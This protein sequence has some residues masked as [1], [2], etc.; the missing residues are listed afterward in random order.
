MRKEGQ[1]KTVLQADINREIENFDKTG[2]SKY[3]TQQT[4][5]I[6]NK[7]EQTDYPHMADTPQEIAKRTQAEAHALAFKNTAF[8]QGVADKDSYNPATMID[9]PD[10]RGR[11]VIVESDGLE[12]GT[13]VPSRLDTYRSGYAGGGGF[14]YD[15]KT[16]YGDAAAVKRLQLE[17]ENRFTESRDITEPSYTVD[18]PGMENIQMPQQVAD[19]Y[20]ERKRLDT[21]GQIRAATRRQ[22]QKNIN[23]LGLDT[24][25]LETDQ[26]YIRP[27]SL[28]KMG[29]EVT[30]IE[31]TSSVFG[32]KKGYSF[33]FKEKMPDMTD[34]PEQAT[35]SFMPSIDIPYGVEYKD[36]GF[37]TKYSEGWKVP[38]I[39]QLVEYSYQRRKSTE[40]DK[41]RALMKTDDKK[42]QQLIK[43][44]FAQETARDW[45]LSPTDMIRVSYEKDKKWSK[46]P[47]LGD[48]SNFAYG[49]FYGDIPG[50]D[51][52]LSSAGVT[53]VTG[54]AIAFPVIRAASLATSGMSAAYTAASSVGQISAFTTGNEFITEKTG[55]PLLGMGG[56]I[57]AAKGF[58]MGSNVLAN[59]VAPFKVQE[60]QTVSHRMSTD[61][62]K[63]LTVTHVKEAGLTSG[64]TVPI[65]RPAPFLTSTGGKTLT[66]NF[67]KSASKQP[68]N[69]RV[70]SWLQGSKSIKLENPRGVFTTRD[71]LG[72]GYNLREKMVN[73]VK[74]KPSSQNSLKAQPAPM[75]QMKFIGKTTAIQKSYGLIKDKIIKHNLYTE[76]RGLASKVKTSG[77]I[78]PE[79]QPLLRIKASDPRAF[80]SIGYKFTPQKFEGFMKTNVIKSGKTIQLM[81]PSPSDMHRFKLSTSQIAKTGQSTAR[82]V[83]R[84]IL[85]YTG[86]KYPRM[87]RFF[88]TVKE[89]TLKRVK[90]F[91]KSGKTSGGTS[92]S[93]GV[94]TIQ[95]SN[96]ALKSGLVKASYGQQATTAATSFKTDTLVNIGLAS[97]ASQPTQTITKQEVK[98]FSPRASISRS[99][100]QQSMQILHKQDTKSVS[101]TMQQQNQLLIGKSKQ[102]SLS[103]RKSMMDSKSLQKSMLDTSQILQKQY[104]QLNPTTTRQVQNTVLTQKQTP[105]T[106]IP[107]KAINW[108]PRTP[109]TFKVTTGGGLMGLPL[110]GGGRGGYRRRRG[111]KKK[112]LKLPGLGG[113]AFIGYEKPKMPRKKKPKKRIIKKRGK[114]R[115]WRK[116]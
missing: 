58:S 77:K 7:Y 55:S 90:V 28:N 59:K 92:G 76:A 72:L 21:E 96:Q 116:R 97:R 75:S 91:Q 56:G 34:W 106:F 70:K 99:N 50:I 47:V 35:G 93:G 100:T 98:I 89:S 46:T 51:I 63:G 45:S 31:S 14:T 15:G 24:P 67:L 30:G 10:E 79:K 112:R 25:K 68:V 8:N 39:G 73:V 71:V 19:D 27:H 102:S 105:N 80:Q 103:A 22:D 9:A 5:N 42:I 49:A 54:L 53:T 44:G 61:Y 87:T 52:E 111:I 3:V 115:R 104:K 33:S 69:V 95:I 40:F 32:Y 113:L 23:K 26:Y 108:I 16:Y 2:E 74:I 107:N 83:E 101:K 82:G 38:V 1:T 17:Q 13:I 20:I 11:G 57:I 48:V 78:I 43:E 29:Y 41:R 36:G 4:T 84:S 86:E 65:P 81:K 114:K 6:L 85:N 62:G 66:G 94:G 18:Y 110:F 64:K 60:I 109:D 88:E 12:S 37:K